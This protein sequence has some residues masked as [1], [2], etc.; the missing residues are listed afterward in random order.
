MPRTY[1]FDHFTAA[2]PDP[3]KR[4]HGERPLGVSPP[5]PHGGQKEIHYGKQHAQ[6]EA[7][8]RAHEREH[9][10]AEAAAAARAPQEGAPRPPPEEVLRA[11][12]IP[13]GALPP[14]DEVQPMRL[15]H[16]AF[17]EAG[18]QV[19]ILGTAARDLGLAGIRIA[20]LPVAVGRLIK[21]HLAARL[22]RSGANAAEA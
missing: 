1:P 16:E 7:L 9:R 2:K 15:V 10:S 12:G 19:R 22:E 5:P 18:R 17:D 4:G 13:I 21:N 20:L 11:R 3:S 6:T 8:Y 14:T